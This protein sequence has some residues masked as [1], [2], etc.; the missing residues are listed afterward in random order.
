MLYLNKREKVISLVNLETLIEKQQLEKAL[1][2]AG[3]TGPIALV[4]ENIKT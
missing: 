3:N 2:Q 4:Y 1:W